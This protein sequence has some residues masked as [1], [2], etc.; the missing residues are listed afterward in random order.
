M[1]KT[2]RGPPIPGPENK[3]REDGQLDLSFPPS[4]LCFELTLRV[5]NHVD[6]L[7]PYSRSHH[8][9]SDDSYCPISMMLGCVGWEEAFSWRSDVG[10]SNVGEDGRFSRGR[11]NDDSCSKFVRRA[12]ETEADEGFG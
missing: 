3:T 2:E 5:G 12:F 4:L 10:M 7:P 11:V 9:I 1:E 6:T 8:R